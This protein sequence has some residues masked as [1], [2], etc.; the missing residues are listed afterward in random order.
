[1]TVVAV[2]AIV[3]IV[4]SGIVADVVLGVAGVLVAV[5]WVVEVVV[6]RSVV[7]LWTLG[8][9]SPLVRPSR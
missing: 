1:M 5:N 7:L 2:E 3:A 8:S 4:A 6:A 9:T